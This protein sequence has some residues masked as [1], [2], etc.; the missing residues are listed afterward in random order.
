MHLSEH[1][2]F[3]LNWPRDIFQ[4]DIQCHLREVL[5]AYNKKM[6]CKWEEQYDVD[7]RNFSMDP[8][9]SAEGRDGVAFKRMPVVVN[10]PKDKIAAFEKKVLWHIIESGVLAP[11]QE[12]S[13][14]VQD[15]NNFSRGSEGDERVYIMN[16]RESIEEAMRRVK[17][18]F[19]CPDA[20]FDIALSSADHV[21]RVP[22]LKGKEE[23]KML[24]FEGEISEFR[25]VEGVMAA[26]RA[27]HLPEIRSI[28]MLKKM[29]E[30]LTGTPYS[31]GLTDDELARLIAEDP[32]G[33]AKEFV[34]ILPPADELIDYLDDL[35]ERLRDFIIAA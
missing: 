19:K 28:A 15:I 34:F 20:I 27:L 33:F 10:K 8:V 14:I 35:N 31:G 24:V 12:S 26:L 5:L 4:G 32:K 30:I 22:V 16:A 25:Q 7:L 23:I 17:E 21:D 13:S 2:S 18:E 6:R 1:G 3:F 9:Y 11:Y 29:H